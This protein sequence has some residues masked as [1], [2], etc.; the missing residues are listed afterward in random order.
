MAKNT[1]PTVSEKKLYKIEI[2]DSETESLEYIGYFVLEKKSRIHGYVVDK[3]MT[4]R[5]GCSDSPYKRVLYG[6]L[7]ASVLRFYLTNAGNCAEVDVCAYHTSNYKNGNP[8]DWKN[9]TQD[10]I[11]TK[12]FVEY[13]CFDEKKIVEIKKIAFSEKSLEKIE[14]QYRIA[15]D[16]ILPPARE[17]EEI[18]MLWRARDYTVFFKNEDES[19][20]E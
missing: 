12:S 6:H 16:S 18:L 7:T 20:Q 8:G 11:K 5:Y 15:S 2:M 13:Y 1:A 19:P 14:S 10:S 9:W 4:R 3:V 17:H